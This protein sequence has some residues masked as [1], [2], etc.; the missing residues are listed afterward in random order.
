MVF[1]FFSKQ[2]TCGQSTVGQT[3]QQ[4]LIINRTVKCIEFSML[5][6]NVHDVFPILSQQYF[7]KVQ[8]LS[9]SEIEIISSYITKS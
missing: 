7:S 6:G 1:F 8:L 5:H 3:N 9:A 2:A 4:C